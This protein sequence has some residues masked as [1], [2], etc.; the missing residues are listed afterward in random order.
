MD[1]HAIQNGL[2]DHGYAWINKR[3]MLRYLNTGIKTTSFD[4]VK[5]HNP[6]RC[7]LVR[8]I[9]CVC[10]S[11]SRLN[12]RIQ[13]SPKRQLSS[14][15]IN[16]IRYSSSNYYNINISRWILGRRWKHYS[17]QQ[18]E[19]GIEAA[20]STGIWLLHIINEQCLCNWIIKRIAMWIRQPCRY[21]C[22]WF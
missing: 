10:Q 17:Q 4:H 12:Q 16:T 11:L 9:C 20:M 18:K 6:I 13:I 2:I 22:Y 21:L 3:T 19:Q 15:R 8:D 5:T 1:Q 7:W 14:I